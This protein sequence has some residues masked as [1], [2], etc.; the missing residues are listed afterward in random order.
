MV[1]SFEKISLAAKNYA[2][3]LIELG[4]DNRESFQKLSEDLLAV[5]EVFDT[6]D[7]FKSVMLNP[8]IN[9]DVKID[10]LN[11]IFSGRVSNDILNFL[12]IL[13]EKKRIS[14]FSQ[15]FAD[16]TEKLNELNNIQPVTIVSAVDLS[17]EQKNRI[18][19][20]L[21][22]KLSKTVMP[23]WQKD[24]SIL[25]GLTVKVNDDVIDMS[26]KTRIDNLS[27]SL[28]LK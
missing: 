4:K 14:E 5:S 6:S 10:I 23:D 27:K 28:M 7:E 24:E 21:T 3:A 8:A 18:V 15:I 1:K 9:D 22:A 11:S 2:E 12:K 16:F 20:K 19:E 25:A 26:L 17:D 13:V